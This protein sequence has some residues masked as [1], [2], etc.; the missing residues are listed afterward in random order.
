[1]IKLIKENKIPII[2]ALIHFFISILFKIDKCFFNYP[3][4]FFTNMIIIKILYFISL[5]F[6]WGFNYHVYKK[7]KENNEIYKR[8]LNFFLIYFSI[9]IFLIILTWPG[10]WSLDDIWTLKEASYY[11]F[12]VWQHTLSPISHSLFL[13]YL[14][15]AAGV[16]IVQNY[17]I[18]LCIA[19]VITK[20]ETSYNLNFIVLKRII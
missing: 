7:I 12:S 11:Y 14:P 9:M 8:G 4:I 1:M 20:L 17:I 10:L 2:L 6:F 15:F 3:D 5:F 18:F 19:F 13:Q 16:I